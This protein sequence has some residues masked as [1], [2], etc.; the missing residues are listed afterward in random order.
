ME[1]VCGLAS[2]MVEDARRLSPGFW[3]AMAVMGH[4]LLVFMVLDWYRFFNG[5]GEDS[6]WRV[7]KALKLTFT[8]TCTILVWAT[9]ARAFDRQDHTR[10]SVAFFIILLGDGGFFLGWSM[11]AV[12]AFALAQIAMMVRNAK[13]AGAHIARGG[14]RSD[15][16]RAALGLA[17]L[18]AVDAA[19]IGLVF[20]D[21]LAQS[22]GWVVAL[23]ILYALFL[24]ASVWVAWMSPVIG[25]F[26]SRNAR[27]IAAAMILF[28]FCD[29][30]VG[31]GGILQGEL[32]VVA[33]NVTWAFYGPALVL[34]ALSGRKA[35]R[36]R[37]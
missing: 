27:L 35:L 25:Y 8:L 33:K 17:V 37:R 14:L 30:T 22:P 5:I 20:R 26:P 9:R 28:Y 11:P 7:G 1:S 4:A 29:I 21:F 18:L 19:L 16:L 10:L 24:T 12:G 32:A 3:V 34:L 2:P 23:G 36:P 13:G 15:A 6:L 31:M